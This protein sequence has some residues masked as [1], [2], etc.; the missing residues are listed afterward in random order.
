[1]TADRAFV[2]LAIGRTEGW[3]AELDCKVDPEAQVSS[4]NMRHMLKLAL[5]Y[6]QAVRA[7]TESGGPPG[8]HKEIA[9][10]FATDGAKGTPLPVTIEWRTPYVRRNKSPV[11]LEIKCGVDLAE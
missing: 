3:Q 2:T 7:V 1:M 9:S 4:G 8:A 11:S 10:P 6:P 5:Q